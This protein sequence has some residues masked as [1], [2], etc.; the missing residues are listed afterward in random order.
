MIRPLPLLLCTLLISSVGIVAQNI[1]E[2]RVVEAIGEASGHGERATQQAIQAALRRAVEQTAGVLI[3]SQSE[4]VDYE[5]ARDRILT[6][7][8]GFVKEYKL[9]DTSRK[10][11]STICRVRATVLLGR[12]QLEWGRIRML[13]DRKGRPRVSVD[14][15]QRQGNQSLK[16]GHRIESDATDIVRTSF[17]KRCLKHRFH[18]VD[19]SR[20]EELQDLDVRA[21]TLKNDLSSLAAAGRRM[22]AEVMIVG[23][24]ASTSSE[25]VPIPGTHHHAQRTRVTFT[26]RAI[27]VDTATVIASTNHTETLA[28]ANWSE[29]LTQALQ[30]GGSGFGNRFLREILESW[31]FDLQNGSQTEL[32]LEGI[33][34]EGVL[35]LETLLHKIEGIRSVHLHNFD[36]GRI[37]IDIVGTLSTV[38]LGRRLLKLESL[39]LQVNRLTQNR[40]ELSRRR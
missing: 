3:Y 33:D 34:F 36:Q 18:L 5:I 23:T 27:R 38:E 30:K 12:F 39:S 15:F 7:S 19:R 35:L 26:A 4:A 37:Q 40:I 1:E 31:I 17:E 24:I 14:F 8:G 22:G 16:A 25:N 20:S 10:S 6:E 21:A 29:A 9:L 2:I 11:G 32:H 13:I 28:A